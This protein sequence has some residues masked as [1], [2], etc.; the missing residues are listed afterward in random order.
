[1][2][3]WI[4]VFSTLLLLIA[5]TPKAPPSPTPDIGAIYTSA[6][7]TVIAELTQTAAFFTPTFKPT[8]VLTLTPETPAPT[9]AIPLEVT[10]TP[11]ECDNSEFVADVNVEDGAIMLPGQDFVKTW[12]LKNIGSCTWTTNYTLVYG[13]YTVKMDGIPLPLGQSVLPGEEVEVSVQFKAP[14]TPGEYVSYW[15]M[16]NALGYPFGEFFYVKIIVE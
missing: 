7:N 5:C 1:M 6:A 13:G 8:A 10:P 16:Q 9:I 11:V 4:L 14:P 2:K 12:R 3:K 15:R